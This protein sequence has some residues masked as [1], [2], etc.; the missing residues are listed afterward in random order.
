MHVQR[1]VS[2]VKM[3]TVLE[4]FTNEK[5]LC[6]V[7][8]FVGKVLS[9]NYIHKEIFPVYDGKCLPRKT[10]T[11]GWQNFTE[12]EDVE[13]EVRKWLRPQSK[14]SVLRVSTHW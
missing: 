7:L 13:T 12:E 14:T 3:A 2:V 9:A 1:L 5:Q 6:V 11:S 8:L 4:K 10:F